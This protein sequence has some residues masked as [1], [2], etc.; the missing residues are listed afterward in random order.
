[1][2]PAPPLPKA[3]GRAGSGLVLL[4]GPCG[5]RQTTLS[6]VVSDP[7]LQ[8]DVTVL[9]SPLS[10]CHVLRAEVCFSCATAPSFPLPS[11]KRGAHFLHD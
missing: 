11:L 1:M 3:V 6:A 9:C 4:Q 5:S 2:A 10:R 8:E 7:L